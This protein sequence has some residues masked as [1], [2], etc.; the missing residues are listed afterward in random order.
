MHVFRD[1]ASIQAAPQLLPALAPL[2]RSR[3][4]DLAEYDDYELDQL[5]NLAVAEP[6]DTVNVWREA[7]GIDVQHR[8]VDVIQAYPGWFELT[9]VLSDDGFGVV[10][11]VPDDPTIDPGLL[12]LCHELA[13][14]SSTA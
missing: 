4:E 10:V 8:P 1:T 9:Y 14:R 5:I 6:S 3:L 2:I 13:Q 7:L 11:Y 12:S